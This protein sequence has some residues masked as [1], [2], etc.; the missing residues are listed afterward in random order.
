M[1]QEDIKI[2]IYPNAEAVEWLDNL[3]DGWF[4]DKDEWVHEFYH[5]QHSLNST[6]ATELDN[7]LMRYTHWVIEETK[8]R[9]Q[10]ESRR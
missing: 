6:I 5:Y 8:R 4:K 3:Y 10:N 2:T 1:K 7:F 9:K